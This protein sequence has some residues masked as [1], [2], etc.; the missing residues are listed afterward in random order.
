MIL[1][2]IPITKDNA[3]QAERLLDLIYWQAGK[4][5]IGN[6]LLAFAGDVHPEDQKRLK[7]SAELAFDVDTEFC[8]GYRGASDT[9]Y[10]RYKCPWLYLE[11]DCVP[12]VPG[13]LDTLSIEYAKQPKRY[14]GPFLAKPGEA[15]FLSRVSI[16]PPDAARDAVASLVPMATKTRLI[17]E[18][19]FTGDEAKIRPDAILLHGDPSGA[20]VE[21]LMLASSIPAPKESNGGSA[22]PPKPA[23]TPRRGARN[24]TATT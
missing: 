24:R 19:R 13:W 9:V 21:K 20:L 11:P 18:L 17:Q 1:T 15:A 23:T 8:A 6:C 12:L 22:A 5:Q 16:Y 10:T 14:M 7:L 4:E 3:K 2:V